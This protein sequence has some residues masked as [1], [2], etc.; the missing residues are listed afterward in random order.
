L[1]LKLKINLNKELYEL[2]QR[3]RDGSFSTQ[4]NRQK[5]LTKAAKEL[6]E[7]GFYNL[8]TRGLKPKH[9][10]ALVS[11]W[12]EQKLS[13]GTI[14]NR[15]SHLR[16]WASKVNKQSVIS[17][18]NDRYGIDHRKYVTNKTK[19]LEITPD[20]LKKIV[21]ERL[22]CSVELQKAFGLRR[23]ESLKFQPSYAIKENSIVL[24][25]SWTKGGRAREIP[26][27]NQYQ[28]EVLQRASDLA[29]SGSMIPKD[30]SF[31]S[32]LNTYTTAIAKADLAKL[33]GLRHSY[34]Q[35]R[36]RELAG[37]ESPA[38]GGPTSRQLTED[39][40]KKDR[41]ARLMISKELGHEREQITAV[42]LGR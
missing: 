39:Q 29:G 6:E 27:R 22:K 7:L 32:W 26:I 15:M 1:G 20:Q 25:P 30:R 8:S 21:N 36:F 5:I 10:D 9:V 35:E 37:F 16:W 24:K 13:A 17:R 19:A 2:C 41:S 40:K 23:E 42:Y 34:A 3:N 31:R 4:Y 28:R 33:H 38:C 18:D 11:Y 12:K 14:K